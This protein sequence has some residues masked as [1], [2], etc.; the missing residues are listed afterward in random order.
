MAEDDA[1]REAAMSGCAVYP[2]SING[3]P[4]CETHDAYLDREGVC[5]VV[6]PVL[7]ALTPVVA[8]RERLALREAGTKVRQVVDTIWHEKPGTQTFAR[9]V[10][11]SIA[12]ALDAAAQGDPVHE[13]RYGDT[14]GDGGCPHGFTEFEVIERD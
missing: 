11:A 1:L 8:E 13:C 4:W 6:A 5:P 12:D 3:K 14:N 10:V 7:A 9:N 2:D